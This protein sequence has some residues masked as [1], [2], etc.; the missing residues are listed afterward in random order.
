MALGVG[1]R[2]QLP[3]HTA[4]DEY[5][6]SIQVEMSSVQPKRANPLQSPARARAT[7]A[8]AP[9]R[10]S[11]LVPLSPARSP[12][13]A[14]KA[15]AA[16][17]AAT[18]SALAAGV[19]GS[20]SRVAPVF[21]SPSNSSPVACP[22]SAPRQLNFGD[23]TLPTAVVGLGTTAKLVRADASLAEVATF[24][25][26]GAQSFEVGC[27]AESPEDPSLPRRALEWRT[28]LEHRL[29]AASSV[30]RNQAEVMAALLLRRDTLHL[31]PTGSGKSLCFEMVAL[32]GGLLVVVSPLQ[33]LIL[34]QSAALQ[35]RLDHLGEG[36]R[37][38]IELSDFVESKDEAAVSER[39]VDTLDAVLRPGTLAWAIVH[40][41]S[42]RAVYLTPEKLASPVVAAA[43]SMVDPALYAVDE[44]HCLSNWGDWRPEYDRVGERLD[45]IDARRDAASA[46]AGTPPLRPP[47][48]ACTATASPDNLDDIQRAMRLQNPHRVAGDP[49]AFARANLHCMVMHGDPAAERAEVVRAAAVAPGY[50]L[51]ATAQAACATLRRFYEVSPAFDATDGVGCGLIYV[52]WASEAAGVAE[53]IELLFKGVTA[54]AFVGVSKAKTAAKAAERRRT[55]AAALSDFNSGTVEWIVATCVMGMGIEFDREVHAVLH[56]G[57]PPSADDYQQ[58]IGRG[59]RWGGR[60]DCV[61]YSSLLMAHQTAVLLAKQGKGETRRAVSRRLEQFQQLLAVLL[62][63]GCRRDLLFSAVLGPELAC[64]CPPCTTCDRCSTDACEVTAQAETPADLRTAARQLARRLLQQPRALLACSDRQLWHDLPTEVASARG[65]AQLVLLMLAHQLLFFEPDGAG[66]T[67]VCPR[68]DRRALAAMRRS[69]ICSGGGHVAV[70]S[71]DA[72]DGAALDQLL[73][74]LA[75]MERRAARLQAK[76]EALRSQCLRL[77]LRVGRVV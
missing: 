27:V 36:G 41:P 54:R 72:E 24:L 3:P 13:A 57:F 37:V 33:A 2:W 8:K 52:R 51:G 11:E 23:A 12:W 59:G 10:R 1:A 5:T 66:R 20:P 76:L 30:R 15:A 74:E 75:V 56:V 40:D 58:E 26:A 28:G 4:V 53:A 35:A 32:N 67:L 42:V 43:L 64:Q 38:L 69:W 39:E 31:A 18:L 45:A 29:G 22:S 71:G 19:F 55:N 44:A 70:S 48:H 46:A 68:D 61:L 7:P 65:C 63:D 9:R 62:G 21:G 17:A 6:P 50:K 16:G 34:S 60:C 77:A 73:D 25:C 14:V 49:G 47:R